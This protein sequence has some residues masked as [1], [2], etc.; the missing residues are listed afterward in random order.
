[1]VALSRSDDLMFAD[2]LSAL[3]LFLTTGQSRHWK[4]MNTSL[5]DNPLKACPGFFV[6]YREIGGD[7]GSALLDTNSIDVI[8]PPLLAV[9]VA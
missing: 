3:P 7:G 4:P 1:M 2:I 6:T 9:L 8:Q 5:N